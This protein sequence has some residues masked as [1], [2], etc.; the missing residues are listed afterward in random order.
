MEDSNKV[1][2]SNSVGNTW[3]KLLQPIMMSM[4][5]WVNPSSSSMRFS[6]RVAVN[7]SLAKNQMKSEPQKRRKIHKQF[8]KV[9]RPSTPTYQVHDKQINHQNLGICECCDCSI[10]SSS[11]EMSASCSRI[12][13]RRCVW[14]SGVFSSSRIKDSCWPDLQYEEVNI[15]SK[16]LYQQC[17]T[18]DLAVLHEALVTVG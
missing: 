16:G 15:E 1:T 3:M 6:H 12:F 2:L 5:A 13:R 10:S 4:R 17:K 18:E 14:V 11:R 9:I 8:G 7:I